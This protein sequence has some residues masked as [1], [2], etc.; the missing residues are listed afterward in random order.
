MKK[1]DNIMLLTEKMRSPTSHDVARLA[2]VSQST[3]SRVFSG[4]KGVSEASKEKILDAAKKLHYRPNAFARGLTQQRSGLIGIV[5]PE[6][7]SPV[8]HDLLLQLS[9]ELMRQGY[10]SLL[11]PYQLSDVEDYSLVK[12]FHYRVEGIIVMSSTLD[13][14]L[15][16]ECLNLNIPLVQVGR[17]EKGIN[18]D[19]VVSDNEGGGR[20]AAESLYYSGAQRI[21]YLS[22]DKNTSTNKER[23]K[24]FCQRIQELTGA[25]PDIYEAKF[26]YQSGVDATQRLLVSSNRPDA[27]FCAND[28]IALGAIDAAKRYFDL[29]LPEQLQ[30]IGFDDI[31]QA[32]WL[33]YQLST[34]KQDVD[35]IVESAVS[36]LIKRIDDVEYQTSTIIVP[37][38]LV[39]RNTS[40]SAT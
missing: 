32:G 10:S 11:I 6:T 26:S 20:L 27:L 38:K 7:F 8:Y 21:A 29:A 12:L 9:D 19:S 17:T 40:K 34:I 16:K 31:S 24:G 3:V 14:Q 36:L 18:S 28:M 39:Q 23:E 37:V 33:N 30:I 15:V 1:A 5:F 2:G 25:L 22:G 4:G 13:S 35:A